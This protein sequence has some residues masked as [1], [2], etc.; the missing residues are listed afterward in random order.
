M[1]VKQPPYNGKP[2]TRTAQI[3]CCGNSVCPPVAEALVRANVELRHV[4]P[5]AWGQLFEEAI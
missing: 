3:R 5:P 1:F 2:L 4:E